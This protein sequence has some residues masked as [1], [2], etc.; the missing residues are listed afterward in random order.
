[1]LLRGLS[2]TLD[3][4]YNLVLLVSNALNVWDINVNYMLFMLRML[5]RRIHN[6]LL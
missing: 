1:V 3:Y 4:A 6:K 5:L 2:N